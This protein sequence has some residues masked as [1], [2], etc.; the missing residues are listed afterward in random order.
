V[1]LWWDVILWSV[2]CQLGNHNEPYH[3]IT[4]K[5]LKVRCD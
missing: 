1:A 2:N 3:S 4:V 5:A